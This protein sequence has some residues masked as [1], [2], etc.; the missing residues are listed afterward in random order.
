MLSL[1]GI[2]GGLGSNKDFI[3]EWYSFGHN[4]VNYWKLMDD[5]E[6]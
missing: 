3:P 6:C 5:M 1:I 4:L 2:K